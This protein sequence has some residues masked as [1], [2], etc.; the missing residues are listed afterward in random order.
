MLFQWP[1]NY[2]LIIGVQAPPDWSNIKIS[3]I[4][5]SLEE[6]LNKIPNGGIIKNIYKK[7]VKVKFFVPKERSYAGAAQEFKSLVKKINQLLERLHID[8]YSQVDFSAYI[9]NDIKDFSAEID[10][11]DI[12][13]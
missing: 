13:S 5:N 10:W 2:H 6:E 4:L 12:A 1:Q 11:S 9:Y 7:S 3:L 8:Y